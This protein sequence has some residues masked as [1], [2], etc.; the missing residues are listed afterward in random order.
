MKT[1]FAVSIIF[2]TCIFTNPGISHEKKGPEKVIIKKTENSSKIIIRARS[3]GAF[4]G[5]VTNI[6]KMGKTITVRNKGILVTFDID[7]LFLKGYGNLEQIKVGDH[8]MVSYTG[9][10]TKIIKYTSTYSESKDYTTKRVSSSKKT[11]KTKT[12]K[13]RPVR[14]RERTYSTSFL[15]VDNNHDNKITPIELS[16]VI[17]N[18]TVEDFRKYDRDGDGHLDEAEYALIN[19]STKSID[20]R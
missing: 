4:T 1:L 11:N 8:I 17:S 3:K 15:D 7:N 19:T 16:T 13:L 2:L 5:I 14:M 12:C 18:L 9:H 20:R 6:N 10:G